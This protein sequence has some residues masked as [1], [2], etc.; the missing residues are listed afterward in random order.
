MLINM[1]DGG[2]ITVNNLVKGVVQYP[3][4]WET[5]NSIL[6]AANQEQSTNCT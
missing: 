4:F 3:V 5:I 1:A 6:T 2:N